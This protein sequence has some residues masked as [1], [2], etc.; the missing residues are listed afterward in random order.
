[1]LP[2]NRKLLDIEKERDERRK[3]RRKTKAK[4]QEDAAVAAVSGPQSAA[5]A[6]TSET[7]PDTS[8]DVTM[9][10]APTEQVAGVMEDETTARA[11]ERVQHRFSRRMQDRNPRSLTN[12]YRSYR[13]GWCG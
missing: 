10:E 11:R 4:K 1:M 7:R 2:L 9:G 3:V 5:S 6:S 8:G 12:V 13:S